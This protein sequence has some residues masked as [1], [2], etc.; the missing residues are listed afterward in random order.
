[1]GKLM[2]FEINFEP[3]QGVFTAGAVVRGTVK[4]ELRDTMKMR[5]VRMTCLGKA[6]VHWSEVENVGHRGGRQR[7]E[8]V[9]Y[10][11]DEEYF[12]FRFQ[13]WPKENSPEESN[14]LG[15][16]Q[17][18][19]PFQLMLP[20]DL[21]PSFEG[22]YGFVRYWAKATIDKPWKF[23]HHTK[24]AFTVIPTLDLNTEP[25]VS[26]P[27]QYRGELRTG[28]CCLPSGR[29]SGSITTNRK[30][31]VPGSEIFL[32]SQIDNH[33]SSTCWAEVNLKMHI[34]YV[35]GRK[36]KQE[37]KVVGT[38]YKEMIPR[39]KTF[40]WKEKMRI[41]PLPPSHLRGC[42]LMKSQYILQF[43]VGSD[44]KCSWDEIEFEDEIII[45]TLP[46]TSKG[47]SNAVNRLSSGNAALP[48]MS[49][50]ER[51]QES[52]SKPSYE[53]CMLF[54][55]VSI[56]DKDDTEHTLGELIF[57]PLYAFYSPRAALRRGSTFVE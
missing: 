52:T 19:F 16:G 55:R 1:M 49:A 20:S 11:A 13:L 51:E 36:Y 39:G 56:K 34:T 5:A 35:V 7:V 30:G 21:P 41:P 15:P 54:G 43:R 44:A 23:D 8:T 33:S 12:Q 46:L 53:E 25:G 10:T 40:V 22:A 14:S 42:K 4:L 26:E 37:K 45:G 50:Q 48:V 38:V 47:S 9:E 32:Q 27:V 57:T 17:H 28:C 3:K 24:R 18:T 29:F 2:L 6:C 31:Y